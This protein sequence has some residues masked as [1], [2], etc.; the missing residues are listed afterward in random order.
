MTTDA[1]GR[2]GGIAKYNRDFLSVL[3]SYQDFTE[4]VA[5]PRLMPKQPGAL[6]S[7]LTYITLGL[8]NKPNY[9]LTV[10]NVFRSNP[11]FGLIVCSHINLLPILFFIRFWIRAPYLLLIYGIDAWKP[12]NSRLVNFLVNKI[13][14]FISISEITKRRFFNWTELHRNK[15][16]I[17]PNAIDISKYNPGPKSASL[18]DRYGLAGVTSQIDLN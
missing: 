15:G 18:Q 13:C 8:K 7:K 5:I 6:P 16:F 9:I 10:L 12:N 14:T 1:Y 4:V 17:L 11:H 2:L 3:C